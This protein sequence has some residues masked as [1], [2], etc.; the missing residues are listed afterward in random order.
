MLQV[1]VVI[2]GTLVVF[3]ALM[4]WANSG[5]FTSKNDTDQG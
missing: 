4:V 1:C 3:A 2:S 5:R